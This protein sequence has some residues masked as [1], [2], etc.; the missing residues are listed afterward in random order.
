MGNWPFFK[1]GLMRCLQLLDDLQDCYETQWS[2]GLLY[3]YY[4]YYEEFML[5]QKL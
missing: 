5:G 4:V 1:L 2:V 3:G